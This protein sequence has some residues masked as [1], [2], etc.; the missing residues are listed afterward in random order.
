MPGDVGDQ[1]TERLEAISKP[2]FDVNLNHPRGVK[3]ANNYPL[4]KGGAGGAR[5]PIPLNPPLG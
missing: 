5:S 2:N 3:F 1:Y 4:A